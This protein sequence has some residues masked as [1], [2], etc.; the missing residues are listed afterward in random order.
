[1]PATAIQSQAATHAFTACNVCDTALER[2]ILDGDVGRLTLPVDK[3]AALY[4]ENEACQSRPRTRTLRTA[5][6]E[7]IAPRVAD[8]ARERSA[9]DLDGIAAHRRMLSRM[10]TSILDA[11]KRKTQ[12]TGA[13]VS[14]LSKLALGSF[15]LMLV[16][17]LL[18][19][20]MEIDR[21]FEVA[22]RLLVQNGVLLFHLDVARLRPNSR[23]PQQ[24]GDSDR[25]VVGSNWLVDTLVTNGFH[26]EMYHYTDAFSGYI[27][28]WFLGR[29]VS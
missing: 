19:R 14:Q 1:M 8:P 22:H 29:K 5:L 20:T 27:C 9:I 28:P 10:F 7:H 15:D 23:P 26:A 12:T 11:P 16:T 13:D 6:D 25:I 3:P 21:V 2:S 18:D 17:Q 24:M 4:C